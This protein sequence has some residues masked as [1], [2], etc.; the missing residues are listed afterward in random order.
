M[1]MQAKLASQRTVL[2]GTAAFTSPIY[3][4]HCDGFAL[5][6]ARSLV[7]FALGR[8]ASSN[9]ALYTVRRGE[10]RESKGDDDWDGE[11]EQVEKLEFELSRGLKR[12]WTP[13]GT[14]SGGSGRTPRGKPFGA[15]QPAPNSGPQPR[16]TPREED[17]SPKLPSASSMVIAPQRRARS[18]APAGGLGGQQ[19]QPI[20]RNKAL[21]SYKY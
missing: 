15:P 10:G 14:N 13:S 5:L 17:R 4:G 16:Y 18:N 19:T 21:S 12:R 20:R 7:S 2:V 9:T 11:E 6:S 1:L 3:V 8:G